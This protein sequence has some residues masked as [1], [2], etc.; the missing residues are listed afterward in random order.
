MPSQALAPRLRRDMGPCRPQRVQRR[1]GVRRHVHERRDR[2]AAAATAGRCNIAATAPSRRIASCSNSLPPRRTRMHVPQRA[3]AR[4]ARPSRR[5][6]RPG[7]PRRG[8]S[9]SAATSTRQSPVERRSHRR[10]WFPAAAIPA[11]R[12]RRRSARVRSRAGGRPGARGRTA[13]PPGT[14]LSHRAPAPT[15]DRR[16]QP[17]AA[18][19]AA[20]A[21]QRDRPRSS[22]AGRGKRTLRQPSW[23]SSATPCAPRAA[24]HAAAVVRRRADARSADA[25]AASSQPAA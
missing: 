14:R 21:V 24:A 19:H 15:R 11:P 13:P 22:S 6:R 23:R 18:G 20:R 1:L 2:A 7:I 12:R 10:G 25:P 16:I 9:A 4:A 8:T 3:R 5:G 17:V